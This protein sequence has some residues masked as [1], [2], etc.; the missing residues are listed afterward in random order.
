MHF[1]GLY[2]L[3][4]RIKTDRE[5]IKPKFR[6]VTISVGGR[7]GWSTGMLYVLQRI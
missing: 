6:M 3:S 1:L 5:M 2:I 4:K 7:V